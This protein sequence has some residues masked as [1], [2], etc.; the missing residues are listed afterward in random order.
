M[1]VCVCVCERERERE[2]R[3]LGRGDSAGNLSTIGTHDGDVCLDDSH[4]SV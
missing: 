4:C 2:S 1:C 3:H